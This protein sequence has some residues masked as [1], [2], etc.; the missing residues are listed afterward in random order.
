VTIL[1]DLAAFRK[2]LRLRRVCRHGTDLAE[3]AFSMFVRL[4]GSVR[5]F[6][7]EPEKLCAERFAATGAPRIQ[8]FPTCFRSH[9]CAKSM[10]PLANEI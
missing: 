8:D 5:A 2:S 10:A 9:A 1:R 4:R 7:S 6:N 3:Q